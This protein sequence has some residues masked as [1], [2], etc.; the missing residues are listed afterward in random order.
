MNTLIEQYPDL[1]IEWYDPLVIKTYMTYPDNTSNYVGLPVQS[2]TQVLYVR[3]DLFT[4]P[5]EKDAFKAKY[6]WDLPQTFEDWAKDDLTWDKFENIAAFFT[7]PDQGLWGTSLQHSKQYDFTSM[8]VYNYMFSLGGEIWDPATKNVYGI[9]NT[10][11]NAKALEYNKH[12]LDSYE[13]PGSVNAGITEQNDYYTSKKVATMLQWASMGNFVA[14][15][16]ELRKIT[17]AVPPPTIKRADGSIARVYG[18]GGQPW[19][20]NAF[21]DPLR[22]RVAIDFLRWWYQP[23]IQMEYAK[24]GGCPSDKVTLGSDALDATQVW[25]QAHK[26]MMHDALQRDFWHEPTYSALL[27]EQQEGW[28]CFVAGDCKDAKAVNEWIACQ[29]QKTQYEAGRTTTPPPDS[30]KTAKLQ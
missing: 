8:F 2:D 14:P 29:Q 11:V 3:Q 6:G 1:N 27:A 4:D 23:D 25:F 28:H 20:V 7:R 16:D 12:I 19:V 30:C 24:C 9:I 10:D 13:P 21:N 17:I 26:F 18:I 5:K 15:T 22:M